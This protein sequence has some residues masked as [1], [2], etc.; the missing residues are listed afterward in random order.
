[1]SNGKLVLTPFEKALESLEEILKHT[2]DDVVRDATIQRFEYTYELAWK[3][4]KRHLDWAGNPNT[5][6]LSK[7]DLFREAAK[8]GIIADAEAWFE[9]HQAR[10]ETSHTYELAMMP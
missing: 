3:M 4:I 7:R 8:T 10:N 5:A 6:S 1:M 9:Y 2:K